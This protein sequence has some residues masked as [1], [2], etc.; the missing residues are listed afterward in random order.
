MSI[1]TSWQGNAF[2]IV[3]LWWRNPSVVTGWFS[4]ESSWEPWGFRIPNMLL[5]KRF[6]C[7]WDNWGT[8]HYDLHYL[9]KQQGGEVIRISRSI[10]LST[11]IKFRPVIQKTGLASGRGICLYIVC[12]FLKIGFSLSTPFVPRFITTYQHLSICILCLPLRVARNALI[13]IIWNL[14]LSN[15]LVYPC[16]FLLP[17]FKVTG[18]GFGKSKKC[19]VT[20]N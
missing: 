2:H 6:K 7:Q 16:M 14:L 20:K 8:V 10:V 12:Y 11:T 3:G 5:N 1:R 13:M 18:L 4:S 17:L 19:I 15:I 9:Y